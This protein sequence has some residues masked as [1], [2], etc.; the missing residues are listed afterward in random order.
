MK[1]SIVSI[2][3]WWHG[4]CQKWHTPQIWHVWGEVAGLQPL[5]PHRMEAQTPASPTCSAHLTKI[6]QLQKGT[7]Q[8]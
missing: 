8:P 6:E 7:C 5:P 1:S 3:L 4:C 2:S